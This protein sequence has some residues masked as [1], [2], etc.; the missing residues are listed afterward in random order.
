MTAGDGDLDQRDHAATAWAVVGGGMLGL[1]LALRLR[2]QGQQV[3]VLRSRADRSAG[4][5]ARGRST[6]RTAPVTWD[7]HYH[8][9]LLSDARCRGVLARARARRR[10]A[11][12]WRRK[13]GYYGDG[14]LSSVSNTRRVPPPA[15][16]ADR[17]E[18]CA[19]ALTILYGS[20]VEGLARLEQE[21]RRDV[22]APRWSGRA[23]FRRF[24]LPL[25]RAKLGESWPDA[26]RRVHLG[27]D[28]A[29]VR[30]RAAA[31]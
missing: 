20:R 23:T 5:R 29:A 2:E 18:S 28:P 17:V 21:S 9:T 3:T 12:G 14:R 6:R 31:G 13:T 8:V 24:W 26:Q 19:S 7:R 1:T 11:S 15:R 10:D 27:D 16:A 4:S 30:A 22:A 25:L